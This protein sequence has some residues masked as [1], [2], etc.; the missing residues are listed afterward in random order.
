MPGHTL[1]AEPTV[2]TLGSIATS[3]MDPLGSSGWQ[4]FVVT[5]DGAQV[6]ELDV[7]SWGDLDEQMGR[8]ANMSI[9][10]AK[11]ETAQLDDVENALESGYEVQVYRDGVHMLWAVPV[12]QACESGSPVVSFSLIE[13]VPWYLGR[14]RNRRADPLSDLLLNGGFESGKSHWTGAGSVV[15]TEAH[16]GTHS[17]EV[18]S[19]SGVTAQ[20]IVI[21]QATTLVVTAKV[22]IES[23]SW[24]GPNDDST[25]L[26]VYATPWTGYPGGDRWATAAVKGT[27]VQNVWFTVG[28]VVDLPDGYWD[29]WVRLRGQHGKIWFDDVEAD[30]MPRPRRTEW[31]GIFPPPEA[32]EVD[33]GALLREA[34][35]SNTDGLELYVISPDTGAPPVPDEPGAYDDRYLSELCDLMAQREGGVDWCGV[36]TPP[37]RGVRVF[38]PRSSRGTAHA[39]F[40][41]T[42]GAEN[43]SDGGPNLVSYSTEVDKTRARTTSVVIGDGGFTGEASDTGSWFTRL[44]EI[45]RAQGATPIPDLEG[46]A[47]EHLRSDPS[48]VTALTVTTH[49]R[50]NDLIGVLRLADSCVV[51]VDDGPSVS[52][53]GTYQVVARRVHPRSDTMTL[54]LNEVA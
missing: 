26:E 27:E 50:A 51:Y 31:A 20:K 9:T 36:Y 15:T 24:T 3:A 52:F 34:L 21:R 7:V 29:L 13:C 54:T 44:E 47:R 25:W 4:A 17:L 45:V 12:Q 11:S 42:F 19:A 8:P 28:A 48:K 38:Y 6:R 30:V 49:E 37:T 10:L 22:Q 2:W 1:T 33:Q 53:S 14:R 40:V 46:V 43:D 39:G 18:N 16:G 41:L 35:L 5:M 32:P 23:S